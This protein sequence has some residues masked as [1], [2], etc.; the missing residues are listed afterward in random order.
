[1]SNMSYC[2]FENTS[3]DLQDAIEK[4]NDL[5]NDSDQIKEMSQYEAR[6]LDD[7]LTAA[8]DL[9]EYDSQIT[10]ILEEYYDEQ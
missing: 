9:I 10:D 7:L 6:G 3:R 5:L 1:M 2:A 8:K 4:V